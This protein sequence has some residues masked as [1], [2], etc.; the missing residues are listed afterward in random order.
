MFSTRSKLSKNFSIKPILPISSIPSKSSMSSISSMRL[1]NDPNLMLK[2]EEKVL[3]CGIIKNAGTVIDKSLNLCI[4][5]GEMFTDYKI[6]IYENN[7]TDNTKKILNNYK[8]NKNFVIISEDISEETIIQHNISKNCRI[9]NISN[10]RNKVLNE[11]RKPEYSDYSYI[12]F[13]DLDTSFWSIQGIYDSFSKRDKWNWD[14]VYANGLNNRGYYYDIYAYRDHD[15]FGPE[16]LG[17]LFWKTVPKNEIKL[18]LNINSDDLIPVFSA[19]GGIGIYKK[20]VFDEDSF[21]YLLTDDIKIFYNNLISHNKEKIE[22]T[23]LTAITNP[24]KTTRNGFSEN[25]LFWKHNS[26][27]NDI[28]VCEHVV[29]NISLLN[30]GYKIFINPKMIYFRPN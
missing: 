14:V 19:F 20:K 23:T 7:S 21:G 6:I 25:G 17:E 22:N 3:L 29:L 30:K 15:N 11:V 26:G 2:I 4:K 18:S 28:V 16:L 5:T 27:F 10:A 1:F 9:Q 13:Y 24:C 8:S 12:I